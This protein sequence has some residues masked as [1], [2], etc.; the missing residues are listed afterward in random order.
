MKRQL[1]GITKRRRGFHAPRFANRERTGAGQ[2]KQK[3]QSEVKVHFLSRQPNG[4]TGCF[5]MHRNAVVNTISMEM[6]K[7]ANMIV[8]KVGKGDGKGD[9]VNDVKIVKHGGGVER[10]GK[11]QQM[12]MHRCA[13]KQCRNPFHSS[14][15]WKF[16]RKHPKVH[17]PNVVA[18]A[19]N[20]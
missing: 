20:K 15:S 8:G 11:R 10:I 5:T 9:I 7:K 4:I 13:Y 3:T 6:I 18:I 2:F 17:N 19:P 1:A 12:K 14:A 16:I